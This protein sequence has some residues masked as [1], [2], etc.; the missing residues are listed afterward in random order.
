LSEW[1][2]LTP[3]TRCH[4]MNNPATL[5]P[6]S[7]GEGAQGAQSSHG[8]VAPWPPLRTASGYSDA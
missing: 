4:A 6:V 3:A 1:C 2:N 7:L 8:G 5:Q